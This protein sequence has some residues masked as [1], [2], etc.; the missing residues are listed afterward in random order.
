MT[1]E[2]PQTAKTP[3]PSPARPTW[4]RFLLVYIWDAFLV[5]FT[6]HLTL[7][8]VIVLFALVLSGIAASGL[9]APFVFWHEDWRKQLLAGFAVA[10]L[11][12]KVLL[13]GF[14]LDT[15][16]TRRNWVKF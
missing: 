16:R 13:V 5:G 12:G 2:T 8:T 15:A 11:M 4:L 9:G 1:L 6:Q 10:L 3:E 14:L 7:V